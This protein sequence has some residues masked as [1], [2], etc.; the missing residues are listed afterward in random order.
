MATKKKKAAKAASQKADG[1]LHL[2][3]P[4]APPTVGG[5]STAKPK[6]VHPSGAAAKAP[7]AG[8]GGA[9]KPKKVSALD[10]AALVL[11]ESGAA[12]NCQEMIAA[13]AGKGYWT[14][15]GGKT[16]Q[17]TLYSALQREINTKGAAARFHKSGRGQFI[18]TQAS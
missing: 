7:A 13:M 12:M 2:H 4:K 15:P 16:P 11:Q 18:R 3:K 6:K 17:A 5:G 9:T 14:S 1:T 10:A 8:S